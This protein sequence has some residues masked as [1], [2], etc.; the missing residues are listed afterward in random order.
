MKQYKGVVCRGCWEL[1]NCCGVCERCLDTKPISQPQEAVV[2]F[3]YFFEFENGD[4]SFREY[5]E[6]NDSGFYGQIPSYKKVTP[7]YTSQPNDKA[8]IARLRESVEASKRMAMIEME[9][10]NKRTA[11]AIKL[12]GALRNIQAEFSDPLLD[13][14]C[15]DALAMKGE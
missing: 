6:Y 12:Q 11:Y 4:N 5:K 1:G 14:M 10:A 2:P 9:R 3:G 13:K 15:A 8:E 7:V